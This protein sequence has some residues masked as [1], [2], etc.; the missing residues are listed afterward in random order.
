M[1]DTTKY[2]SLW[3]R[4]AREKREKA[5]ADRD[6]L[7]ASWAAKR[8]ALSA[9]AL[10]AVKKAADGESLTTVA[11]KVAAAVREQ[12]YELSRH[13]PLDAV[14]L[15]V[16]IGRCRKDSWGKGCDRAYWFPKG[17][18][19]LSDVSCPGCGRSYLDQTTLAYRRTFA[20]YPRV[21]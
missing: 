16:T 12:G 13:E 5:D 2:E 21:V 15:K 1:S 18:A 11:T 9:A 3:E 17:E 8:K 19:R 20:R 6:A 14:K 4:L 10:D 7:Q